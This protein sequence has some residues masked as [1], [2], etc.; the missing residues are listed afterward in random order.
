MQFM[1]LAAAVGLDTPAA[2]EKPLQMRIA[3]ISYM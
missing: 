3:M 1:V 2:G